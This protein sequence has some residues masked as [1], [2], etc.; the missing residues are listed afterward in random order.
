MSRCAV[1]AT[2]RG[3][4]GNPR[5]GMI[6]STGPSNPVATSLSIDASPR[7]AG[8]AA[9]RAMTIAT[10]LIAGALPRPAG[11]ADDA[12]LLRLATC[13]DSW[14]DWKDS[15]SRFD[16]FRT[17]LKAGMT[18]LDGGQTFA[19]KAPSTLLGLPVRD[20]YPQSIGTGVGFSVIVDADFSRTRA[21]F[22]KELGKPMT[23]ATSDGTPACELEIGVRKTVTLLGGG[24]GSR[25]SLAGC[26]YFYEK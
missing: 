18:S 26:Y 14:F 12:Q 15:P 6:M 21:A 24:R 10:A 19:P 5:T 2:T 25:A 1:E 8:S 16:A 23:C 7:P 11:A 13:R 3:D 9:I 4:A 17:W 22:E 20:V